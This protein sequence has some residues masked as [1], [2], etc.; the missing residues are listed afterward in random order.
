MNAR[1]LVV[2]DEVIVAKDIENRLKKFGHSVCASVATG[3]EAIKKVKEFFPDLVLMDIRLKGKMDGVETAQ[4]IYKNFDIPVIYLTAN[5]DESTLERAKETEPFGYIIKPFKEKELKTTIEIALNKYQME[6]KLK[7]S[8]QWL[9]TVLKS[10]GDGVI[11]SDRMGTVTFMNPVAEQLTGWKQQD[12]CGKEASEIFNITHAQSILP[13]HPIKQVLDEGVTIDLPEDTVLIAKNGA[14]IPIADSAAPIKDDKGNIMGAVLVFRD[15]TER[16][17][18]QA[19]Q[20]KQLE[21]ERLLAQLEKLNELKDDF[22]S[23]VSHELRTPMSNM[24]MAIQMLKSAPTAERSQLYL[25]ILQNECNRE[26]ELINDV[27]DMQRLE[28]ASYPLLLNEN[29]ILK[30]WLP[31]VVEPFRARMQENQQILHLNLEDDLPLLVTYR[32]SLERILA[33]LL[34]NACKYTGTGGEVILS[35]RL[36]HIRELGE[37]GELRGRG[38]EGQR[39]LGELG[40]EP[41]PKSKIQN[42][43]LN[44]Q[45]PITN[46]LSIPSIIFTI[47]NQ[48]E[49]PSVELPRIFEKFYRVTSNDRWK[50]GGTGL[51]LAL[52][53][54]LVDH[55]QGMIHVDSSDGWTTFTVE[56]P[57]ANIAIAQST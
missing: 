57:N 30:D 24:K 21:Q 39:E 52:V 27:L 16:Q 31:N 5:A 11:T 22:L 17:Q 32:G 56:L 2:K 10:I 49:I 19:A 13:E 23:T 26:I 12:A 46:S 15:I 6:K 34:N 42:P 8:E 48:A 25:N 47:S 35:V 9:T 54:K 14:E 4:I 53:Q 18:A 20:K 3:E 36:Q 43:K 55:L 7:Q 37:L 51:G 44:Y 29:I 45:L 33:E 28:S 41:N 1:I 40:S 38:A 50:R